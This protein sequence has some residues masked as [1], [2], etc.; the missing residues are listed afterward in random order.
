[1]DNTQVINAHKLDQHDNLF[2]LPSRNYVSAL[3]GTWFALCAS[4][5]CCRIFQ[6]Q[7]AC[8]FV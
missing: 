3:F 4:C 1:M 6:L 5:K 8:S 2:I 7:T